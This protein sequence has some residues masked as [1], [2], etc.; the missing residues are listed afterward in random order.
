MREVSAITYR[1]QKTQ[2]HKT[3]T[4]KK[5][6]QRSNQYRKRQNMRQNEIEF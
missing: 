2:T 1:S 6:H 5:A 4:V 3:N